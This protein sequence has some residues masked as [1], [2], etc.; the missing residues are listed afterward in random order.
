MKMDIEGSEFTVLPHLLKHG[1]LCQGRGIDAL[2]IE[3]H[4][5]PDIA[6]PVGAGPKAAALMNQIA[7]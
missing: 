6:H 5:D 4:F 1:L 7:S 2:T 3:W